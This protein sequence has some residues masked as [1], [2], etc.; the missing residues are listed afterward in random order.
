M[1]RQST[2]KVS[3]LL[4]SRG[5]RY[6][7][8]LN[9]KHLPSKGVYIIGIEIVFQSPFL[10]GQC[11]TAKIFLSIFSRFSYCFTSWTLPAFCGLVGSLVFP[12]LARFTQVFAS[13]FSSRAFTSP[14]AVLSFARFPFLALFWF[15]RTSNFSL[16][17]F[18]FPGTSSKI[19]TWLKSVELKNPRSFKF[20]N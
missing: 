2:L 1:S 12:F 3:I 14:N 16:S 9:Q 15:S 19:E 10:S 18:R 11:T 4:S 7:S 17:L 5:K 8:V 13:F 20:E 6:C